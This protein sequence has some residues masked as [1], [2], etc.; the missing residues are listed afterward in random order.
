MDFRNRLIRDSYKECYC[1]HNNQY[2]YTI[3]TD[4]EKVRALTRKTL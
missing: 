1:E 4:R 2:F 3:S